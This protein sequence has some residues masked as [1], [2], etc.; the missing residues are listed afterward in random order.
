MRSGSRII[1]LIVVACTIVSVLLSSF[2]TISVVPLFSGPAGNQDNG[3]ALDSSEVL[4]HGDSSMLDPDRDIRQ[5]DG[6]NS[7][8]FQV[9]G[10][11]ATPY[12]RTSVFN[13]YS[14][15]KW[16]TTDTYGRDMD[17]VIMVTPTNPEGAI[18][19]THYVSIVPERPITGGVPV[20]KETYVVVTSSSLKYFPD[21]Q[22]FKTSEEIST[23]YFVGY[24]HYR[25]DETALRNA[26]ILHDDDYSNVPQEYEAKIGALA[27]FVTQNCTTPFEKVVAVREFLQNN[28]VYDYEYEQAPKGQD[29]LLWF[30]FNSKKGVCGHFNTAFAL[31][32]RTLDI[33]TRYVN[34]YLLNPGSSQQY[35]T[36]NH[37]HAYIE[38]RFEGMGW[39]IFDATALSYVQSVELK[40][41]LMDWKQ[42]LVRSRELAN[43]S[44]CRIDG[45]IFDDKN[46]DGQYSY[47]EGPARDLN[48]GLYNKELQLVRVAKTNDNGGFSFDHLAPDNYSVKMFLGKKWVAVGLDQTSFHCVPYGTYLTRFYVRHNPEVVGNLPSKVQIWSRDLE[49]MQRATFSMNGTVLDSE[50]RPLNGM[51]VQL[52][53]DGDDESAEP[54]VCSEGVVS[55]GQFTVYGVMPDSI[56]TGPHLLLVKALGDANYSQSEESTYI[57]VMDDSLVYIEA[58]QRLPMGVAVEFHLTLFENSS[59][60]PIPNAAL[61]LEGAQG[62]EFYT[63]E[64]GN[65]T[66]NMTFSEPGISTIQV[67]YSGNPWVKPSQGKVDVKVLPIE[68][69]MLTGSLVRGEENLLIGRIFA[70]EI[71]VEDCEV[72]LDPIVA[73]GEGANGTTNPYGYF[74][75]TLDLPMDGPGRGF[76]QLNFT[77]ANLTRTSREIRFK[78]RP[79]IGLSSTPDTVNVHLTGPSNEPIPSALVTV[80]TTNVTKSAITDPSGAATVLI[81]AS[82][83]NQVTVSFEGNDLYAPVTL[84]AILVPK[85]TDWTL[86]IVL[87]AVAVGA[88]AVA[89]RLRTRTREEPEVEQPP[90]P[91]DIPGPYRI[92]FPQIADDL[93]GVWGIGEPLD[94]RIAGPLVEMKAWVDGQ[95]IG[96]QTTDESFALFQ[97][98]L[99][100]GKHSIEAVGPSG[101]SLRHLQIVDYREHVV[102][103]YREGLIA[104]RE[105]VPEI[106][107]DK[108]PR[109]VQ[110]LLGERLPAESGAVVERM[111]SLFEIAEF[112]EH[113]MGRAQFEEMYRTVEVAKSWFAG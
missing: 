75:L 57:K 6:W 64:N 27:E 101:G 59:L 23:S 69:E 49:V 36:L 70:S 84:D 15:G 62:R 20:F 18:R 85:T 56:S 24:Y 81:D 13:L 82:A 40:E 28:Y 71:P 63:D 58:P 76:H 51:G 111:V 110:R 92:E 89:Y 1:V 17:D 107:G 87:G 105:K 31:M 106:T 38:V 48:V 68:L 30:L 79:Q 42:K 78:D 67:S 77:I 72:Q 37:A 104:I 95:E 97:L 54:V 11:P 61:Y 99:P 98:K 102:T 26:P 47:G 35:V 46:G 88:G 65:V 12:L 41:P 52:L 4:N 91:L 34:G 55:G 8:V 66:F 21:Y 7:T 93:P 43:A 113:E 60:L 73:E 14:S 100:Y 108:A 32:L 109:E 44:L 22:T 16:T 86:V 19:E 50:D 80:S 3:M 90:A 94:V 83:S 10:K 103:L 33:P 39:V 112:S 45:S 9:V 96:R 2:P 29:P 5:T 74:T 53:V 25:Y